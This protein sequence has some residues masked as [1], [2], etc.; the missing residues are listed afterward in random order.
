MGRVERP[1]LRGTV[2][3]RLL[4]LWNPVMKWLLRSPLNW[5]WSRWFL[6]IEWTGRRTGRTY[7]TPVSYAREGDELLITTGDAWWRNLTDNGDVRV[8]VAGRPRRARAEP[9][10]DES[11]S[12]TFHARMFARRPL[13][14]LLAGMRPSPPGAE[15]ARSIRSGRMMIRVRGWEAAPRSRPPGSR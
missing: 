4:R 1:A 5:P 14:A 6:V 9:V 15:I 13:F 11:E 10:P 8:W 12:L 2:L 7:R 3:G